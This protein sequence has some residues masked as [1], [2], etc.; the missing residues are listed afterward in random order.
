MKP[1]ISAIL[2]ILFAAACAQHATK[3]RAYELPTLAGSCDGIDVE[4][5]MR[6]AAQLEQTDDRPMAL[7]AY[8]HIC[9]LGVFTA[10]QASLRLTKGP[11][12]KTVELE[13]ERAFARE[14]GECASGSDIACYREAYMLQNGFGAPADEDQA[15][16]MFEVLCTKNDLR[17]CY[18]LALTFDGLKGEHRRAT[19]DQKRARTLYERTCGEIGLG[20]LNLANLLDGGAGGPQDSARA[21][22]LYAHDCRLGSGYACRNLG[23]LLVGGTRIP[24]DVVRGVRI[25][26]HGCE[27]GA[28]DACTD[29]AAVY[30]LATGA[31]R[32][33][34]R[35]LG[36]SK[37]G[38]DLGATESCFNAGFLSSKVSDATWTELGFSR[39]C[40]R[41]FNEACVWLAA[42]FAGGP[43]VRDLK[44]AN[45]L[46]GKTCARGSQRACA[47]AICRGTVE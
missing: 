32:N 7:L 43:C 28:P 2:S 31:L 13:L 5:C 47:A 24:R 20:C 10:C 29:A 40:N 35:A 23:R 12:A 16:R 39:A 15:A 14:H 41:G 46:F 34:A 33:E 27:I 25:L 9:N 22:R 11:E 3:D 1:A 38:C 19:P 42:C 30:G 21:A 18:K 26:E 17:A 8:W 6:V 4:A 44:R 37:R 36:L 45:E